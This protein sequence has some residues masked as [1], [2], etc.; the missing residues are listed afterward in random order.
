MNNIIRRV[1]LH[2]CVFSHHTPHR[3]GEDFSMSCRVRCSS[4][5]LKS[6]EHFIYVVSLSSGYLTTPIQY[7]DYTGLN[8]RI[9]KGRIGKDFDGSGRGIMEA[10]SLHF[11]GGTEA[12]LQ[13]YYTGQTLILYLPVRMFH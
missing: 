7:R 10:L 2:E 13:K 6:T 9:D 3:T 8:G 11:A 12:K 4:V 1:S 5:Q